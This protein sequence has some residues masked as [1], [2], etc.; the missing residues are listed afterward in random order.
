[1]VLF[2]TCHFLIILDEIDAFCRARNDSDDEH[3]R[4]LKTELLKQ[5]EG[6]DGINTDIIIL[7]ATN[8]PWYF[9]FLIHFLYIREIDDAMLRRFEKRIY[10]GLPDETA[11]IQ[12][13][14]IHCGEEQNIAEEEYSIL[15]KMT[16]GYSG[17]DLAIVIKD[18]FMEP[19]REIQEAKYWKEISANS[20]IPASEKEE[21]AVETNFMELGAEKIAIPR[22]MNM[23]DVVKSLANNPSIQV[24]DLSLYSE[25][26]AKKGQFA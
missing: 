8:R 19:L 5:I 11:R 16:D 14:K 9:S 13:F 1:M 6:M 4:R 23:N 17:S 10:I 21:N 18:A 25:F 7:A 26:T 2:F 24:E 12:L 3:S 22:K 15:G 20:W